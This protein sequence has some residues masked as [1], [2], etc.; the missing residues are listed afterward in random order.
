VNASA[1][2]PA[3]PMPATYRHA[4]LPDVLALLGLAMVTLATL[5]PLGLTNRVLAGIDA[6]TYFTPYW[7]YRMEA[8][9]ALRIPL[10]NPYLFA[11]VP[12]LANIQAAVLYPLHWP[13]SWMA[14]ERAIIWSA[15]LH[16]WLGCALAYAFARRSLRL[17]QLAGFL[18]GLSFGLGGFMLARIE[19]INQLNTLAWLPGLL[20]LADETAAAEGRRRWRWGAALVTAM[21][22]QLLAGHTQA[23]FVNLSALALYLIVQTLVA[24]RGR[25]AAWSRLSVL[26]AVLPAL[27][28]AAAQLLPSIELMGLGWR[29]GG[30]PFRQA[31][32]FSLRPRLLLQSLLPPFGG[33]LAEAFGDEGYA[34]FTGYLA[35]TTLLLAGVGMFAT[36]QSRHPTR[37]KALGLAAL[38]LAGLFLALGA[39]NPLYYLLW[40][41]IPGFDLFRAPVRWLALT[42]IGVAGLAGVGLD[43]L[44]GLP[45]GGGLHLSRR[46]RWV[47]VLIATFLLLL[48]ALQIWP[49]WPIAV[50]WLVAGG[51]ALALVVG[52]RRSPR[53]ARYVLVALAFV[54]FWLAAR[55]L[56]FTL[57]TAPMALDLRNAPAALLATEPGS[58]AG[59]GRLLSLSDIRYDPGDL[60]ALRALQAGALAP[61]AIDRL[62]RAAKLME[63]IAPNLS[64]LLQLP[65]ADGYDGG[66]LPT[67][68]YVNLMALL[69]PS[70]AQ[71]PDG[72]LR[73][74]LRQ[75]PD[76]RMLD[77]LGVSYVITDKQHDLWADDVYYDL[78]HS[79]V[80]EPGQALRLEL[81]GR[82]AP[83]S[84][85]AVGLV[86]NLAGEPSAGETAAEVIIEAEQPPHAYLTLSAG[87]GTAWSQAGAGAARIARKWPDWMGTGYD[88]LARL[89]FTR[90]ITPV[91]VTVRVPGEASH[92]LTLRGLSLIDERTGAHT[93]VTVS[94]DGD[95]RRIH[96]GD[97]KVYERVGAPGR[98]WLVHGI[99]PA[100][101]RDE[102][103]KALADPAFD[104]R[105]SVV[106][107]NGFSSR[108]PAASLGELVKPTILEPEKQVYRVNSAGLGALVVADA[109]YPGWQAIVDGYPARIERANGAFRAIILDA[110]VHDVTLEYRPQSWRRGVVISLVSLA[111]LVAILLAT[112]IWP[113]Q[114]RRL[115]ANAVDSGGG[116]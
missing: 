76:A 50:G 81:Q 99:T 32:S 96:S 27:A 57:A 105:T 79:A 109:F 78:E 104:P 55:A 9:R 95:L 38:A 94:Q 60:A 17:S 8:L 66:L 116:V 40:R 106:L 12:F 74:Q 30:L 73:E 58:P 43:A 28:L 69:L 98:A 62:V 31:V 41:L 22:L 6:L 102:A 10:W 52:A 115:G 15:I 63:V 36:L 59:R 45:Q 26:L 7:A 11:G 33:G 61:E 64:L 107:E 51:L 113:G 13:L 114:S 103:L 3:Q 90:P 89:D 110:G 47:L 92:A 65:A 108:P 53:P 16:V 54:E 93:S 85:T 1:L 111:V 112:L 101:S 56:P 72:R 68:D 88:Y 34:E 37:A 25:R 35:L 87:E 84:A 44:L 4:R 48:L 19:N 67:D 70:E 80:L 20:W 24:P 18:A 71:L 75:T 46:S 23:A 39:Y 42:A 91:A 14:P 49:R 100:A 21:A 82:T 97:V 77:V 83:F 29:T 86:T 5:W 2:E